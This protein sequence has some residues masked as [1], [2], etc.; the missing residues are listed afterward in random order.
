MTGEKKKHND[1]K[2][3][4]PI[5]VRIEGDKYRTVYALIDGTELEGSTQESLDNSQKSNPQDPG[6]PE[7]AVCFCWLIDGHLG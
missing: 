7:T 2:G 6:A 3:T 1:E 4:G 5:W